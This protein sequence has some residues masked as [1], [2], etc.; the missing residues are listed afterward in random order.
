[1]KKRILCIIMALV[2]IVPF[3]L[4]S[5]GEDEKDKMKEIILGGEDEEIDRALTL[6]I[7]LPTD[8]I[9]IKGQTADLGE[10]TQ[11]EKL[12]LSKD[13]P[14][15]YD[16]LKRVDDVEDS[17]NKILISRN[18]YTNI[19]IVPINNEYYE[20]AIAE[21]FAKMD[22]ET[23]PFDMNAKGDSDAYANEV[24]E[25]KVGN[26]VLYNL[27]Y[28]PVDD[29]QLD[30]FVIRDYGEYDG[31]EQYRE[32]IDKNYLLPLNKTTDANGVDDFFPKTNYISSS[33]SYASV[34]K[35]IRDEFMSQM[36]VNDLIY[37]LPNNHLYSSQKYI[38]IEKAT[39]AQ[40]ASDFNVK[41]FTDFNKCVEYINRVAELENDK[42]V[43]FYVDGGMPAFDLVDLDSLTYGDGAANEILKNQG[44]ID[45]V[46][47]YKALEE[48]G[49]VKSEL[50]GEQ[51][52][53]VKV[54]EG[55]NVEDINKVSK[56]YYLVP[57]GEH[58][59][60]SSEV[61]SSM[62]AI[63]TFTIDY[64]RAM[65]ILNLLVSDSQIVTMLQYGIENEDYSI[66]TEIR[67]GKE[68]EVLNLNKD[69]AYVMNNLYTGSN[70]YT[71]PH[72]GATIN[73]WD[74]VKDANVNAV[75]SKYVNIEYYLNNAELTEEDVALLEKKEAL[76]ELAIKAFD[77]ISKMSSEEFDSFVE[78]CNSSLDVTENLGYK[79][80]YSFFAN[81]DYSALISLYE[82]V[83]K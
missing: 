67:N 26:N 18:Y 36:K 14:D 65:K 7:W 55:T 82:R 24:T 44:F 52:A 23:N 54:Y 49:L 64:D 25:E 53:A 50:S 41:D 4:V 40:F 75:V 66:T 39:F 11:Q 61:Y 8:A 68:V 78:Y 28:R 6:S 42:L 56:D 47:A 15:V 70:Y 12:T 21:R 31:Y 35:L 81:G 34:F 9:T 30:L 77:D 59:V 80:A 32:Y 20:E 79:N 71:F 73:E 48:G 83:V 38:A 57:V 60:N 2:M 17:I 63:S 46:R 16:F 22:A 45:F 13:Y 74:A 5:C 69:T 37:A 72:A 62:F 51:F 27:L 58:S 29:N 3:V 76:K 33:G 43:P 10:L 19:D 1:M